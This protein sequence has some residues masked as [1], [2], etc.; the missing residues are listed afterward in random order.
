MYYEKLSSTLQFNAKPDRSSKN[1]AT[2]TE[3]VIATYFNS[4]WFAAITYSHFEKSQ[5]QR[6]F[7]ANLILTQSAACSLMVTWAS[8]I[9]ASRSAKIHVRSSKYKCTPALLYSLQLLDLMW[10]RSFFFK[11]SWSG[12]MLVCKNRYF[13][14]HYLLPAKTPKLYNPLL[15]HSNEKDLIFQHKLYSYYEFTA[16][17]LLISLFLFC[18]GY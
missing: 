4:L 15:S 13:V 8:K 12:W 2:V 16:G 14:I 9:V 10:D 6:T 1:I 5:V 7:V 17:I 18:S 11:W 3:S